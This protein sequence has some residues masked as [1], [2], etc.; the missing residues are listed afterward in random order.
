MIEELEEFRENPCIE[1]A[2]DIYEVWLSILE[3]WDLVPLDVIAYANKKKKEKGGF[4]DGYVL[5]LEPEEKKEND[6]DVTSQGEEK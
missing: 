3:R 5:E 4:F 2:A 1:E 6:W